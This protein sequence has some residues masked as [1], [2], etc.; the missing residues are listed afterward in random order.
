[1]SQPAWDV[2]VLALFALSPKAH[3]KS[4][5]SIFRFVF[6]CRH[7]EMSRVFTIKGR[8][9]RVCFQCGRELTFLGLDA[10]SQALSGE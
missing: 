10:S 9:Y 6:K 3:M 2:F 4:L 1:M 5:F 7:Q 8:T